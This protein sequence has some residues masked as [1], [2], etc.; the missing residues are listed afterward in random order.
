ME[1]AMGGKRGETLRVVGGLVRAQKM[2]ARKV[3]GG[4]RS[5]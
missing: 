1:Q 3:K 4:Q 5:E 2:N